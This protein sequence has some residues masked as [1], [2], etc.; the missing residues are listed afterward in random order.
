MRVFRLVMLPSAFEIRGSPNNVWLCAQHNGVGVAPAVA[1]LI[2][3]V[4]QGRLVNGMLKVQGGLSLPRSPC[5]R[6]PPHPNFPR[7]RP[8]VLSFCMARLSVL[9]LK[10]EERASMVTASN[11]A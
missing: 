1:A 3:C 2:T 8:D 6:Q 9:S 11:M 10:F 4:P 7:Q 5:R